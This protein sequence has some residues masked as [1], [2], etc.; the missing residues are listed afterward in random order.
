MEAAALFAVTQFR[1]VELG[2][3][4]AAGDD[5]SGIEWDPRLETPSLGF[6][7]RFFSLA[8]DICLKL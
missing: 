5:I 7:E 1:N 8:A 4:L 2:Y 6:H 3:L